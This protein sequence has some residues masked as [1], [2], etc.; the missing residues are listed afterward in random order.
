MKYTLVSV[1]FIIVTIFS[2]VYGVKGHEEQTR[3]PS[4]K[5]IDQLFEKIRNLVKFALKA[6]FNAVRSIL[7]VIFKNLF[8]LITVLVSGNTEIPLE[9]LGKELRDIKDPSLKPVIKTMLK[10]LE[11]HYI[12]YTEKAVPTELLTAKINVDSLLK[13]FQGKSVTL[14]AF[15][16]AVGTNLAEFYAPSLF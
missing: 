3:F 4:Q 9:K 12:L 11:I 13:N 14:S 10:L 15:L 1:F 7:E 6:L 2:S 8:G 16:D 5:Q